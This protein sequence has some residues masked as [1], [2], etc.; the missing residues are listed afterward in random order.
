MRLFDELKKKSK[1][2]GSK[3][4]RL[5]WPHRKPASVPISILACCTQ[6]IGQDIFKI[7]DRDTIL[8]H[9]IV[10]STCVLTGVL[11]LRK[12]QRG[13]FD[14]LFIDEAAQVGLTFTIFNTHT[15]FILMK[16]A[17]TRIISCESS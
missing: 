10:V 1:N 17:G 12:I 9:Q 11:R 8:K 5:N 4:L 13:D 15:N 2:N 14:Y 7:P 3:L 6:E 16:G